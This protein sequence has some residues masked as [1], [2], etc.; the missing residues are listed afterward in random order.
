MFV[1]NVHLHQNPSFLLTGEVS[2]FEF[3]HGERE[4]VPQ[5]QSSLRVRTV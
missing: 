5:N 4:R 1:Q 3:E 2:G